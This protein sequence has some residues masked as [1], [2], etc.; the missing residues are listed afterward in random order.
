[1]PVGLQVFND[2]G[3]VQIDQDYFSFG[4]RQKG[5]AVC[6]QSIG[7][8]TAMRYAAVTVTGATAPMIAVHHSGFLALYRVSVSG[9]TWTFYFL[10]GNGLTFEYFI[11]D[12]YNAAMAPPGGLEIF[13]ASGARVF[14]SQTPPARIVGV[15]ASFSGLNASRKY[16]A[17]QGATGF[18]EVYEDDLGGPGGSVLYRA[19]IAGVLHNGSTNISSTFFTYESYLTTSI[20]TDR[21]DP[22][23]GIF[24]FD[25]T[26]L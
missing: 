13:N 22:L 24:L 14:S 15:G 21:A 11:F 20:G 19:S 25:V 23:P 1:M 4:L 10:G 3:I 7:G 16:A 5:T 6:N 26:A 18:T 2:D 8:P 12:V 17:C 9:S